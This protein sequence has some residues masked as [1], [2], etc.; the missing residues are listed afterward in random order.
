MNAEHPT[1]IRESYWVLPGRFLA[2]E[3]PRERRVR[4]SRPKL[5]AL[6]GAGLRVFVDLTRADDRLEPYAD[7][8]AELEPGARHLAFPVADMGVPASPGQMVAILDAVD[9]AL[10]AGEGVYLHCWGGVGRTGTAVGC[11]LARHGHPGTAALE[12]LEELWY[13]C[14]KSATRISPE[15][16][17][18]REFVRC[19]HEPDPAGA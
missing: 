3:Y 5:Q 1:P 2:G 8:L 18:Q 14:P 19:W 12:R 4:A 16:R 11:W 6:L 7:L 15:T 10:A 13:A 17:E 9:A